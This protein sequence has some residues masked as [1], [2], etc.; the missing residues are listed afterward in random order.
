MNRSE[1]GEGGGGREGVEGKWRGRREGGRR[2]GEG[3]RRA[4]E[5]EGGIHCQ[6]NGVVW[7]AFPP[8]CTKIN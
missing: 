1:E 5:K 7:N 3:G 8:N 2:E 6:L 4:I